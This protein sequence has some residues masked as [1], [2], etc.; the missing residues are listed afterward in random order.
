LK[1]LLDTHAFLWW[2]TGDTRLPR[3]ARDAIDSDANQ[4][5]VSAASAWEITTKYRI[6]KLDNAAAIANDVRAAIL[7]QSF[8]E[9]PVTVAHGQR[10]G[11]LL[12]EH[13]DPFDRMLIAQAILEN[14]ALVSNE[15]RFDA[16]AVKRLW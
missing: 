10:A 1:L 11:A 8:V 3:K 5:H 13:R 12:G 2:L 9:L 15:A 6:G 7:S 16:F 4:T 14:M